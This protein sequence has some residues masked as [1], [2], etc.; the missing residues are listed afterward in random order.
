MTDR[1]MEA[2]VAA[3]IERR[4]RA[5]GD[6]I[7]VLAET[8]REFQLREPGLGFVSQYG[9]QYARLESTRGYGEAAEF[10]AGCLLLRHRKLVRADK[11]AKVRARVKKAA[12]A[13]ELD[14]SGSRDR[15]QARVSRSGSSATR[16][17]DSGR[18]PRRKGSDGGERRPQT[19]LTR[20]LSRE[21]PPLPKTVGQKVKRLLRGDPRA[22]HRHIEQLPKAWRLPLFRAMRR[23]PDGSYRSLSDPTALSVFGLFLLFTQGAGKGVRGR[24]TQYCCVSGLTRAALATLLPWNPRTDEPV[25]ERT[26]TR[27]AEA[28]HREG[29]VFFFQPGPDLLNVRFEHREL[30]VLAADFPVGPSGYAM[31]VYVVRAPRAVE[32]IHE[33]GSN[34]L[35]AWLPVFEASWALR[36]TPAQLV[37]RHFV[38]TPL[39]NDR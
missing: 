14:D 10:L 36:G 34:E 2:A 1:S 25:S 12:G 3:F 32:A 15:R 29:L 22:V 6:F 30:R 35:E 5:D 19:T 33:V 7:E 21:V 37:D 27:Y 28:L 39:H 23:R 20:A 24:R 17:I 26:I 13:G 16:A 38:A 31:N 4:S 9:I 8:C 18:A 11:Q